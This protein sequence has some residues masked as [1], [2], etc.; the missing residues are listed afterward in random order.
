MFIAAVFLQKEP[1]MSFIA[2]SPT[3]FTFRRK[4]QE[5]LVTLRRE[6]VTAVKQK[7]SCINI[8]S[9][10][11]KTQ[12]IETFANAMAKNPLFSSQH[13]QVGTTHNK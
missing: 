1:C 7:D 2:I 3:I 9:V 12:T 13:S 10:E 8:K 6:K 11:G 4:I 5:R